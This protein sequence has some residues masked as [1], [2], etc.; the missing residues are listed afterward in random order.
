VQLHAGRGHFKERTNSARLERKTDAG[1]ETSLESTAGKREK[2]L[3]GS[4]TGNAGSGKERRD[5]RGLILC[6]IHI[7]ITIA[8]KG[9][10]S[11]DKPAEDECS[12]RRE[13][14]GQS[15]RKYSKCELG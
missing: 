2:R 6:S 9:S 1:L 13:Q 11:K 4:Q 3:G 7:G 12:T 5:P 8:T 15:G 10:K 14:S